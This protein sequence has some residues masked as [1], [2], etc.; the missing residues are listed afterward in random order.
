APGDGHAGPVSARVT[1]YD[2]VVVGAGAGGAVVA[3]RLSED[4]ATSVLLLEAGPDFD[5]AA[6]PDAVRH[7]R[8]GSGVFDYDWGY[9]DPSIGAALPRGRVVGGSSAVNATVALRGQ[10]Q[11]YDRWAELGA[12]GW[13][14]QSCLPY[15]IRLEDDAEFGDRPRPRRASAVRRAD[16]RGSRRAGRGRVQHAGHPAP[17]RSRTA[18]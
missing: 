14:W 7:V 5:A 15:F 17:L 10:P 8:N 9:A 6:T 1:A 13:D 4:R 16:P 18:R 11:D 12:T 3:S 2:V